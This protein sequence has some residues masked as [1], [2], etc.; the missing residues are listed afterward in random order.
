[1]AF[2]AGL[3]GFAAPAT[4]SVQD[5]RVIAAG[6]DESSH[7]ADEKALDYAKKRAVYIAARKIG[8]PST[9]AKLEKFTDADYRTI[10]RGYSVVQTR[11]E[12]QITYA[13]VIVSIVDE[14]LAKALKLP[15][16][17]AEQAPIMRAVMLLPVYVTPKRAF[18]WEKENMLR[19]PLADE[20]RRKAHG[21]VLLPGGGFEDMRL[22]D[23]QNALTVTP[24]E[25]GPMFTRYGV[26]EIIV[27]VLT[28]GAVGTLDGSSV[29]LRRLKPDGTHN[30]ILEIPAET[31]D[32]TSLTRVNRAVVAI[33]S[34][35][36]QIAS[37]TAE[38]E[39]AA[40]AKAKTIAVHFAYRTPR[41]LA[42][43]Q[44]AVRAAPEV[45][46]LALPAIAL[47]QVMGTIYLQGDANTLRQGLVKQ[48][49]LVTDTADGWRLSTR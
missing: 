19:V 47:S 49:V 3:L 32:D 11:R 21:G 37:S 48:G 6:V 15:A 5:I 45:L 43:M 38:A 39:Q 41:D 29:L 35:V 31:V 36:T 18:V 44:K 40:R 46:D 14:A 1:M 33:A 23:H 7:A 10:I 26:D 34:A 12:A 28:P 24:D 8:G 20:L 13:E 30:E 25:M 16:S 17:V 27:A 22:I 42:T 2:F 9:T 4:A